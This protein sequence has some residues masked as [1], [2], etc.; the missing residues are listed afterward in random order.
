[1]ARKFAC[2][3][4]WRTWMP[5]NWQNR[6]FQNEVASTNILKNKGTSIYVTQS[7]DHLSSKQ[8]S[9]NFSLSITKSSFRDHKARKVLQTDRFVRIFN[10]EYLHYSCR[11]ADYLRR[12]FYRRKK[13][14]VLLN[15]LIHLDTMDTWKPCNYSASVWKH[16]N[17]GIQNTRWN[18]ILKVGSHERTISKATTYPF[19]ILVLLLKDWREC[20]EATEHVATRYCRWDWNL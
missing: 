20:E 6:N 11:I 17:S 5:T 19:S 8:F 18:V 12:I 9:S 13:E 4:E 7:L 15:G 10:R 14:N 1:M 2:E 3:S 16:R